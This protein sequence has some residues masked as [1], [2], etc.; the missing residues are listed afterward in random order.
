MSGA[1][2]VVV[3]KIDPSNPQTR[4]NI[5]QKHIERRPNQANGEHASVAS[6]ARHTLQLMAMGAPP[7]LLMGSQKAAMDEIR[8]AKMCYG[9]A[10][11]FLDKDIQP[12]TL[13]I[14]GS[15]KALSREEII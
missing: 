14:D 3:G 9:I 4:W 15:V 8:H 2:S 5:D 11:T 6:F 10:Q 12:S 1:T 13:D 7:T